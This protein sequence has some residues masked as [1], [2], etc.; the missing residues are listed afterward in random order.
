MTNDFL[1][2][3]KEEKIKKIDLMRIQHPNF[4]EAL[5]KISLCHKSKLKSADPQCLLIT[6]NYGTGKT[7]ILNYYVKQNQKEM[8][9][10]NTTKK[11]ILYG[12]IPS[13][14]RINTFLEAM[15]D[16]LGDPYAIKGT[17]GNKQYR[18][19]NLIKDS[20]VELIMLDEF[21]HFV[22]R[23]H[24][25]NH[26][27]ADCFKSIINETKVPVVLLGLD[28]SE[29]VLNDNG[30]LKR[31]FSFRHHLAD[32]N[33]RNAEATS[34]FRI[35]L[36]SIDKSLPFEKLSGLKEVD[37]WE[38]FENATKGNMSALM[39]II[40]TAAIEA[41]EANDKFISEK[42]FA[43]AFELHSFIMNG[44]NPFKFE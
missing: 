6:G 28:E 26:D 19:V 3:T 13:P 4:K 34:Q 29:K 42:R 27:V 22:H 24:Q 9:L 21:Q 12:S 37:M 38:K 36:H 17:I 41:V 20:E 30:Q 11:A 2:M 33:C 5:K 32:F 8:A 15:L 1:Q 16:H 14:T 23:N 44:E 7:T 31:R 18:L 39:K 43:K 10:E 40:R 35:L 25:V